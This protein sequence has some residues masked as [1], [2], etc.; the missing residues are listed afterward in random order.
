M[1]ISRL[2][3]TSGK[4]VSWCNFLLNFDIILASKLLY[5]QQVGT[6]F[7]FLWHMNNFSIHKVF[8]HFKHIFWRYYY[9][10]SSICSNSSSGGEGP[11]TDKMGRPKWCVT[12]VGVV[13]SSPLESLSIEPSSI[14]VSGMLSADLEG[15]KKTFLI[16]SLK[17]S[18]YNNTKLCLREKK[19]W[20]SGLDLYI[21]SVR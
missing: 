6:F 20:L 16:T 17:A 18:R 14:V 2:C 1:L 4:K 5:N 21:Q 13:M 8:V 3:D 11:E 15:E 12:S 9:R 7:S 19:G 10:Y